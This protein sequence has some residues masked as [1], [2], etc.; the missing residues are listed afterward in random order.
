MI[1]GI[2]MVMMILVHAN[3]SFDPN[4]KLFTFFQMGCQMF[5]VVSG[6]CAAMSFERRLSNK[7]YISATKSFYVKKFE[8]IAP[9]W[10]F[11]ILIVYI[12]NTV[13][14]KAIGHILVF[15]INREP[16]AILCNLLFVHGLV[17]RCNNNVMPGGWYIGTTMLLYLVTP[18][19]VFAMSNLNAN[20]K[21]VF[22]IVSSTISVGLLIGVSI[23]VPEKE[24]LL[25]RNRP[26]LHLVCA[27]EECNQLFC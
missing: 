13:L 3:Q 17:P 2:A 12:V 10:Y 1:K 24:N 11:M 15:G 14:L 19:F 25:Y 18:A 23:V 22:V 9:A 8:S 5:F 21:K 27:Q 4:V 20:W 7:N 6:F 26:V 16:I